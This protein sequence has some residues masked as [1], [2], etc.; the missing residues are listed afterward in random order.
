M[1]YAAINQLSTNSDIVILCT[2]NRLDVLVPVLVDV[3]PSVHVV[4]EIGLRTNRVEPAAFS[5]QC[6]LSLLETRTKKIYN[7]KHITFV[8]YESYSCCLSCCL[9]I[10]NPSPFTFDADARYSFSKRFARNASAMF[11]AHDSLVSCT[12]RSVS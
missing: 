12:I 10:V 9:L 3:A 4:G 8:I 1:G 11:H 6:S 7:M 5:V 2:I